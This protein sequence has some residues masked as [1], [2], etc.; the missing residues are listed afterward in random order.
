MPI[1]LKESV[2]KVYADNQL[3]KV[4]TDIEAE[5]SQGVAQRGFGLERISKAFDEFDIYEN[6]YTI[7]NRPF[8][9]PLSEYGY[10]SYHYVLHDTIA[11]DGRNFYRIYFFPKTDGDLVLEGNFLVDD[12]AF[13]VKSIQMYTTPKT[14][15]NMVRGMSFEK[16]F[17]IVNDSIYLPESEIQEGDFTLLTKSDEEKGIYVRS[18]ILYSD[19]VLNSPKTPDFYDQQVVQR[20]KNQFVK[21]NSYWDEHQQSSTDL[22][23]TKALIKEIGDNK[24]IKLVT[25]LT[26]IIGTGYINIGKY[27]QFGTYWQVFETNDVEKNRFRLGFRTF[28]STEDRFRAYTYGAFGTGDQKFKYGISAKY[29]LSEYPRISAGIGY[30][31]DYLQL[32]NSL[33]HDDTNLTFRTKANYIINRGENYF[34]TKNRKAQGVVS[35][36]FHNN[37]ELSVFGMLQHLQSANSEHFSIAFNDWDNYR[38]YLTYTDFNTGLVLNYTPKRNVFGYGVEQ[39]YGEKVHSTYTF[40]YTKGVSGAFGSKFDYDKVQFLV[41]KPITMWRFGT[42]NTAIEVGKTF[43]KTPLPMLSPTPSNQS[44][45][46]IPQTFALLDYYDF[47]TDTYINGHFEQHFNGFIMNKLPLINKL[48][49]RSLAFARFAYG[50]ISEKN[51]S[52]NATNLIYNAPNKLYWEYGFGIENIGFG[53]FRFFRVDF[54]W[55]SDFNDVNGLKNPNFGI[56]VG[57]VPIF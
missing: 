30:Q 33:L 44:Y 37:L 7:L 5:R 42:L 31:D 12:K 22:A 52:T 57:I 4:R 1:Y 36:F 53:N 50:T 14:N 51:I 40:K 17:T 6:S 47:V 26:D 13:V 16:H 10:G 41:K 29:L 46:L 54:V 45:S 20:F 38:K 48:R 49:L 43:G 56:R 23:K 18:V 39:R 3:Q 11:R 2:V 19:V 35:Y 32:G 55:R 24:R 28:T 15:I 25:D 21:D 27:F 34:L 9:S 8:V